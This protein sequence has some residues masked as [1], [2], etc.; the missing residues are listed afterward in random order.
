M[1]VLVG[2][3]INMLSPIKAVQHVPEVFGICVIWVINVNVEIAKNHE[4]LCYCMTVGSRQRSS[5]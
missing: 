2:L 1:T 4:L 5:V 3:Y